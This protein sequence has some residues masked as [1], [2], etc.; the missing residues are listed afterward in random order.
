M[1]VP[2]RTQSP[3]PG[4]LGAVPETDWE[5][6]DVSGA[7]ELVAI[8]A[9]LDPATILNAYCRGLFP[10]PIRR[11]VLGT[12]LGW[13]SPDPRG[14]L[15]VAGFHESRSLR[16]SRRRFDIRIDTSFPDVI[17]ECADPR[18]PHGWITPQIIDAYT[19]L[20]E[21]GWVHSVE[22]VSRDDGKL[23]GGLYGVAIGG[24]FA[25]ESM[26]HT[27][28]DA[29]KAALAACIDVLS[30]E[31]ASKRI[32]DVQWATPHLESLGVVS[33]SRH[34]YITALESALRLPLPSAFASA[35]ESRSPAHAKVGTE[36][37]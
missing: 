10:M 20:F 31:Y 23:A 15:P 5:F 30:D 16:R 8:G 19:T 24:L 14:V 28:T 34:A 7:D 6:P 2:D 18:R 4:R 29:G 12:W 33:I 3:A 37:P 17:R 9:D 1:A 36:N 22:A 26:F 21:R 13:W 27:R 32:F 25:A 35:A 11:H